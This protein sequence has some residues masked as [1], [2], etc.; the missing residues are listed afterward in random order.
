MI[1]IGHRE[2]QYRWT[3][4]LMH[5]EDSHNWLHERVQLRSTLQSDA[6]PAI[7][8]VTI[9]KNGDA[10]DGDDLVIGGIAF[11]AKSEPDTATGTTEFSL[12]ATAVQIAAVIQA[13][14]LTDYT[15]TDNKNGE[16][17]YTQKVAGVGSPITVGYEAG[18]AVTAGVEL[19]QA[20]SIASEDYETMAGEPVALVSVDADNVKTVTP[21]S[22][23]S[24]EQNYS[25]FVGFIMEPVL[26]RDG[27]I[28][29]V[30]MCAGRCRL[31]I[32]KM[33]KKDLKGN[34]YDWRVSS[35]S[36]RG[37]AEAKGFKFGNDVSGLEYTH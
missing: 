29:E 31:N 24:G 16:L 13:K 20:H 19:T 18:G 33:L 5:G 12:A 15:I 6:K 14:G 25:A 11:T 32:D 4:L 3:D 30:A 1:R 9:S 10:K 2:S 37:Y 34:P 8:T 23:A 7:Y 27:E 26:V 22:A 17:T 21:I 35:T 28:V 36:L